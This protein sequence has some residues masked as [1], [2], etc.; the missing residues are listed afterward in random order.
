MAQD[1]DVE[2]LHN[3]EPQEI[4]IDSASQEFNFGDIMVYQGK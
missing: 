2:V 1:G 4:K 3:N